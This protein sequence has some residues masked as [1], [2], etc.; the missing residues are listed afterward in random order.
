MGKKILD[1]K[2]LYMVLAVLLSILLWLYVSAI[3]GESR[4]QTIRNIPVTFVGTDVL[5]ENGLMLIGDP[6][7]VDLEIRAGLL[8]LTRLD[9]ESLTLNVN[10]AQI[11]E[12]T[13][14][15]L[16]Y[17]VVPPSGVSESSYSIVSRSPA[18]VRFTVARY[19]TRQVPIRGTLA[20][21]ASSIAEGFVG[22]GFQFMPETITVSGRADLVAQV[23]YALVTISGENLSETIQEAKTYQLFGVDNEPLDDLDVTCSPEVVETTYEI[24]QEIEV[25]LKVNLEPGGGATEQNVSFL[26][27]SPSTVSVLGKPEDLES[28][29][30]LTVAT[31]NLADIDGTQILNRDIPLADE[32][33]ISGGVSTVTITITVDGLSRRTF[34]VSRANF[35]VT[36]VPE[37]FRADV[38]T[39]SLAVT[40]RG[41]EEA[42]E[43]VSEENIRVTVDLSG[44]DRVSGQYLVPVKVQFDGVEG[45]GVLNGDYQVTVRLRN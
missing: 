34:E 24:L 33:E 28:L 31:I 13:E 18:N 19:D 4:T 16:S 10:V 7:T 37:G 32:L 29:K 40:I 8:T 21:G 42:L 38:S 1:S 17:D 9:D 39:Q 25:P 35:T 23:Q 45:T 30:E 44:I 2:I 5:Q 20:E 43:Q 3:K 15:T 36:G 41:T 11:T 27:I 22:G 6:P 12:P 14:Y 26:D